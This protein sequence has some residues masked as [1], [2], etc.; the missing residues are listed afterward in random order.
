M[1]I[2]QLPLPH[3]KLPRSTLSVKFNFE[4]TNLSRKA[5]RGGLGNTA[6]STGDFCAWQCALFNTSKTIFNAGWKVSTRVILSSWCFGRFLRRLFLS[7]KFTF[8]IPYLSTTILNLTVSVVNQLHLNKSLS[9]EWLG[10]TVLTFCKLI[11]GMMWH[12][13]T[14][15]CWWILWTN[16]LLSYF[17]CRF[18]DINTSE[19]L[20]CFWE[21]S[22]V[23]FIEGWTLFKNPKN[24]FKFS[25]PSVHMQ[26]ISS[27]YRNQR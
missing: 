8:W 19:K 25:S 4:R 1:Q 22:I 26:K 13:S 15:D 27:K 2:S 14:D 9:F 3:G 18:F 17:H 12:V 11:Y 23:N 10:H 6:F 16:L 5:I 21:Y 7:I 24:S 20:I